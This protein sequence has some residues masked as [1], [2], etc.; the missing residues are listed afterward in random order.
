MTATTNVLQQVQEYNLSMLG[1]LENITP[2]FAN[3]N[4]RFKDFQNKIANLGSSTTYDKP[5]R[6]GSGT[7]LVVQF[8]SA[9]Q[10]VGTLTCDQAFNV[11]YGFTAQE[12]IFNVEKDVASYMR[13]FGKGAVEQIGTLIESNL[14]L[15]A[16]SAVPVNSI[17]NG[18]TVPT[19]ALHTESGPYRFFGNG[20]NPINS[21]QQL[22]QMIENFV[23]FG[24]AKGELECYLPNII[25]P[26]IVGNGLNQFVPDR[27]DEIANSW[28]IGMF[29]AP[30]CKFMKSNLLPTHTSGT[31]GNNGTTLTV[32]ST[33]DPTGQ[34]ISQ[35]TCS[36]ASGSADTLLSGDL[37]QFQDGVSGKTN[38]RFLTYIGGRQTGQPVQIRIT[39]NAASS[40]GNITFNIFPSLTISTAP[41]DDKI[42]INSNIV[43]GMQLKFLPTHRAGLLTG[44][45]AFFLS[46]P[47]LPT[48]EP[49][50]T[51]S[52]ID[53]EIGASLRMTS[54]A[55][56]GQNFQGSII[57]ETHGSQAEPDYCMRVAIPV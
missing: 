29:G 20:I 32:T 28:E 26:A 22:D 38:L 41:Q 5:T 49:F 33:N 44:G 6:F 10:R 9:V 47:K 57:D 27:N 16:I 54:G 7:G 13:E 23:E 53:P 3:T 40:G 12:R 4:K 21:F 52:E 36:G 39:A 17:V 35:I 1:Y 8:Q 31:I 46:M 55:L 30:R 11:S 42:A 50:P 37:G 45:N 24:V 2:M 15:N 19:G 34:S 51:S 48:Q 14:S 25:F 18:Q 56:F 43:S